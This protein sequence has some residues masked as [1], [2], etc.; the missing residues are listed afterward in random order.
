VQRVANQALTGRPALHPVLIV[1]PSSIRR[2]LPLSS[3]YGRSLEMVGTDQP[4][5][6]E[7]EQVR[8][9]KS[10]SVP[11]PWRRALI[12]SPLSPP[13]PF[14]VP[15][16]AK[17]LHAP[18]LRPPSIQLFRIPHRPPKMSPSLFR[19]LSR[20]APQPQLVLSRMSRHLYHPE[21][22]LSPVISFFPFIKLAYN[23]TRR[24]CQR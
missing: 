12:G 8:V 3:S 17:P 6:Y 22:H 23:I 21:H 19:I 4:L 13:S 9:F 16:K 2:S 1:D 24:Q 10:K 18:V 7:K 15:Q 11:L 5:G 20:K 14:P